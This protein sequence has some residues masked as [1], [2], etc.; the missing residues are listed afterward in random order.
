MEHW[1]PQSVAF[2]LCGSSDL[3]GYADD[4]VAAMSS[5]T[6]HVEPLFTCKIVYQG[7]ANIYVSIKCLYYVERMNY[8]Q[9]YEYVGVSVTSVLKQINTYYGAS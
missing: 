5:H 9:G 8:L 4:H 3:H 2:I 6:A 7:R 1:N